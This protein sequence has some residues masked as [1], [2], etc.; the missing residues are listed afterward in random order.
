[1][2]NTERKCAERALHAVCVDDNRRAKKWLCKLLQIVEVKPER[3]VSYTW[4]PLKYGK[5]KYGK[6]EAKALLP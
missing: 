6:T 3:D 1:M 5:P 4:K 2:S